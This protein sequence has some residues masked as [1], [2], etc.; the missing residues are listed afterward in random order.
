MKKLTK[1]NLFYRSAWSTGWESAMYEAI[2]TILTMKHPN[3]KII[4]K[5]RSLAEQRGYT[6][7][8]EFGK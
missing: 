5:L 6:P 8:W 4:R 1:R 7:G 3:K 2:S